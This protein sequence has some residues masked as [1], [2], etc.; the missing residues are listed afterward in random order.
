MHIW[1][2][3]FMDQGRYGNPKIFHKLYFLHVILD[4]HTAFG[5]QVYRPEQWLMFKKVQSVLVS[6]PA[7]F[8]F[9][10]VLL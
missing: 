10:M 8:L 5:S 2:H 4:F 7:H 6:S 1:Y 9:L 3:T